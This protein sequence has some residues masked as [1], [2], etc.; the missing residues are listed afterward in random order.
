MYMIKY[1][2]GVIFSSGG[3]TLCKNP[4]D[5]TVRVGSSRVWVIPL[6]QVSSF[7]V[8]DFITRAQNYIFFLL[9]SPHLNKILPLSLAARE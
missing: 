6:P 2:F 3:A 7:R 1:A 5:Q 8:P 4:S 9:D